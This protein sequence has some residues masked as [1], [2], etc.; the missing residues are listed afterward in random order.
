MRLIDVVPHAEVVSLELKENTMYLLLNLFFLVKECARLVSGRTVH[1]LGM[2]RPPIIHHRDQTQNQKE[3]KDETSE[4]M[5]HYERKR[6]CG[7]HSH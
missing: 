4:D 5:A 6:K 7:Q 2:H 1:V 3:L